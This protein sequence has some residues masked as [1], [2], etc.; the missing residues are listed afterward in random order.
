MKKLNIKKKKKNRHLSKAVFK[1]GLYSFK[2]MIKNKSNKM[3]IDFVEADKWFPSSKTC[4]KCGYIKP[5]LSLSERVFECEC[6]KSSIDRD[7]NASINLSRYTK[8]IKH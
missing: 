4:S 3:G 2:E 6:C 1:Q 7:L 8:F 5:K